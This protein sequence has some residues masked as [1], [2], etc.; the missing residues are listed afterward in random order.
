MNA[1]TNDETP[2]NEKLDA[3]TAHRTESGIVYY[4]NAL[5]RESTY[6]K[7]SGFKGE[8]LQ[9]WDYH[10]KI[11]VQ[12]FCL[13]LFLIVNMHHVLYLLIGKIWF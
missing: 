9:A 13:F 11:M 3:W 12:L 6:E 10:K 7:P 8:V 4:Y 5:T 2:S 1:E